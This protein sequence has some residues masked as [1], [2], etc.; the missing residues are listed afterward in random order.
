MISKVP[1]PEIRA[2]SMCSRVLRLDVWARTAR[3]VH[4][5]AVMPMITPMTVAERLSTAMENKIKTTMDGI[6]M[7]TLV[8]PISASSIQPPR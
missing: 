1:T 5:Q 3:A 6:V 7:R 2:M 4:G 8:S